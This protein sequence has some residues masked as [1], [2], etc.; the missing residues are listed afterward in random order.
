MTDRIET[1]LV[2]GSLDGVPTLVRDPQPVEFEALLE[3]R[4]QLGLDRR[5]E[6]WN[7][8]YRMNPPPSIEHQMIAHQLGLILDPLARAA[9]LLAVVQEFALGDADEYVVPDGGLHLPGA[10]GVWHATVVLAIEILSPGDDTWEKLAFYA[11]HD[12]DELLIVDPRE[13]TVGW[14]ALRDDGR[15]RPVDC[16]GLIELGASGLAERITWPE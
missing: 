16:S 2:G 13:R 12:V 9:G 5:D 11:A 8:V 15:Y 1:R 4:R 10:R 7:G 14:L 6:L 3:R